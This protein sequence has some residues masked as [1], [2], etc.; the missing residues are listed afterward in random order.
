MLGEIKAPYNSTGNIRFSKGIIFPNGPSSHRKLFVRK[1][2]VENT[3][4]HFLAPV[5]YVNSGRKMK[6]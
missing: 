6:V 5:I 4:Q 3:C 1:L 2:F